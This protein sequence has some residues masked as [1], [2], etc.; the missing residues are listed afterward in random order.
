MDMH[1]FIKIHV[2]I[3]YTKNFEEDV[4]SA[5]HTVDDVRDPIYKI[6]MS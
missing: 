1:L 6:R 4:S 3:Y 2:C 5:Y